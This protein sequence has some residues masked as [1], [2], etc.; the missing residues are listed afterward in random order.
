MSNKKYKTQGDGTHG[1]RIY[2][3]G[4]EEVYIEKETGSSIWINGQ[5]YAKKSSIYRFHESYDDA[6]CYLDNIQSSYI[7]N[8]EYSLL[9]A[10]KNHL[11]FIEKYGKRNNT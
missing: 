3:G 2:R 4:I 11:E 9:N 10:K 7:S 5:R 1:L 6:Y 8:L